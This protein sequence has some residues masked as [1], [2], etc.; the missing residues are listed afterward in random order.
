[1]EDYLFI[2][3]NTGNYLFNFGPTN[4]LNISFYS[5]IFSPDGIAFYPNDCRI[6]VE[7][8]LKYGLKDDD[9]EYKYIK[10]VL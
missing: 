6:S 8:V 5:Y 1:M 7:K 4:T 2:F 3:Y 10:V 9:N